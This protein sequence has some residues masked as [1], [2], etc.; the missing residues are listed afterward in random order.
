MTKK[1]ATRAPHPSSPRGGRHPLRRRLARSTEDAGELAATADSGGGGASGMG[2]GFGSRE[3]DL[4]EIELRGREQ[5]VWSGLI[6]V[7]LV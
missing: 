7:C 4:V 3:R 5:G 2:A 1:K 6:G